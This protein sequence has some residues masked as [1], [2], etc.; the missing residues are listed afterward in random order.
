[1]TEE[2][3]LALIADGENDAIAI[4]DSRK[5]R[6]VP[7]IKQT[8]CAMA[9]TK[10]GRIVVGVERRSNPVDDNSPFQLTGMSKRRVLKSEFHRLGQDF[11]PSIETD[12]EE[13][14]IG[15][16]T[17]FIIS[18][19]A[20]RG[21]NVALPDGHTWERAGNQNVPGPVF[22]NITAA[23]NKDRSDE[24]SHNGYSSLSD[25]ILLQPDSD[26]SKGERD[27]IIKFLLDLNAESAS[28]NDVAR[29]TNVNVERVN[30]HFQQLKSEGAI[31]QLVGLP[32]KTVAWMSAE[33]KLRL[34]QILANTMLIIDEP[35]T[36][37][38]TL[39][40]DDKLPE[41]SEANNTG[42]IATENDRDS[43]NKLELED[44]ATVEV[45]RGTPAR[46]E[47]YSKESVAIAKAILASDDKFPRASDI[48]KATGIALTEVIEVFGTFY[49]LGVVS[50]IQQLETG[51]PNVSTNKKHRDLLH[52]VVESDGDA[53]STFQNTGSPDLDRWL[54][55]ELDRFRN[56]LMD[57]GKFSEEA[58]SKLARSLN[59]DPNTGAVVKAMETRL[60]SV[61]SIKDIAKLAVELGPSLQEGMDTI[62]GNSAP[63]KSQSEDL[64]LP[65]SNDRNV[66]TAEEMRQLYGLVAIYLLDQP[67]NSFSFANDVAKAVQADPRTVAQVFEGLLRAGAVGDIELPESDNPNVSILADNRSALTQVAEASGELPTP[68]EPHKYSKAAREVRANWVRHSLKSL[69]E[70]LQEIPG[71]HQRIVDVFEDRIGDTET[72]SDVQALKDDYDELGHDLGLPYRPMELGGVPKISREATTPSL[73]VRQYSKVIA[74]LLAGTSNKERMTFGLFGHWGRGKT[75]MMEQVVSRLPKRPSKNKD[76]PKSGD[77]PTYE[78]IWFSAWKYRTTPETWVYLFQQF[79]ARANQRDKTIAIVAAVKKLGPIAI[80]FAL[81]GLNI[82]LVSIGEKLSLLTAVTGVF[83]IATTVTVALLGYRF[84]STILRL[85]SI[86]HLSAREQDL[87]MQAAIGRDLSLLLTSWIPK[88]KRSKAFWGWV[89]GGCVWSI[90][91]AVQLFLLSNR[92]HVAVAVT[93]CSVWC[94]AVIGFLVYYFSFRPTPADRILL[95]VDDLDRCEPNQMLEIIESTMLILSEEEMQSRLQVAMLVDDFAFRRALKK[96]YSSLLASETTDNEAYDLDRLVRE[97]QEKLFLMQLTLLPMTGDEV[98]Q[99]A[100]SLVSDLASTRQAATPKAREPSGSPAGRTETQPLV[101]E[102]KTDSAVPSA[103]PVS[104]G[105]VSGKSNSA[106]TEPEFTSNA[107]EATERDALID[108]INKTFMV[109][110]FL[111]DAEMQDSDEVVIGP[112]TIQCLLHRYQFARELLKKIDQPPKPDELASAIVTAYAKSDQDITKADRSIVQRIASQVS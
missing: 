15:N 99:V 101:A 95:V 62:G 85:R 29:D 47:G 93:L 87:G 18:V 77:R 57:F 35:E 70:K 112:R 59:A 26:D 109:P 25:D 48:G 16:R 8:V 72:V 50:D 78:V 34:R 45:A 81:L 56:P 88:S 61:R 106:N 27:A 104:S 32:D 63:D 42:T 3:V 86:Y 97:N 17:V 53:L 92:I 30:G 38:G 69:S 58:K 111:E 2:E 75:Y 67:I 37:L 52:R 102:P 71:Q 13:C 12:L 68:I 31:D 11:T 105:V 19:P 22:R 23:E 6:D 89:I 76:N 51:D 82:S 39:S 4:F 79:L 108:A 91:L 96:K 55:Y 107:I 94:L 98:S 54:T 66:L 49:H 33:S 40:K 5:G 1:M 24:G 103:K 44:K 20:M 74:D 73:S 100:R 14:K 80:I 83:G 9:N 60:E 10:G 43:E 7:A 64:N 46:E 84:V 110:L 90:A 36:F 21:K 41:S 28:A 65:T